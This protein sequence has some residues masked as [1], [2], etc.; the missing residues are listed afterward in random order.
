VHPGYEPDGGSLAFG[1]AIPRTSRREDPA[2]KPARPKGKPA[3]R[4][5]RGFAALQ[6]GECELARVEAESVRAGRAS[7]GQ[8][9]MA[10]EIIAWSWLQER[11]IPRARSVLSDVADRSALSRCLLAALEITGGDRQRGLRQVADA[12]VH[13]AEGPPKRQ[14]V[15]YVGRRGLGVDLARHLLDLP[16][17]QG[18]EAAVRLVAVLADCGRRAQADQVSE[19][20]FGGP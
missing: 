9:A 12:L 4:L 3:E 1:G 17:G 7:A 14:V 2:P 8:A 16:N 11:N 5:A 19:L 6:R 15:D 10:A 20:L 18:F 13:E